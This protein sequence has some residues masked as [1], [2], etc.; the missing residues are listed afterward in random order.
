MPL[1]LWASLATAPR[2]VAAPAE[3]E[4]TTVMTT[5]VVIK[6][7]EW[8][9]S[10]VREVWAEGEIAAEV[11]DIQRTL[12]TPE[13]FRDFMPYVKGAYHVG[14]PE[15]DGS[16]YVYTQVAPPMISARD[17]VVRVWMDES[18]KADGSGEFRQ[19]WEAVPDKLPTRSSVVRVRVNSGS[20]HIRPSV[21]SGFSWV[22]YRFAFDPGGALP[23][24]VANLGNER[25]VLAT[26]RAVE[27][28]ARRLAEERRRRPRVAVE[29]AGDTN[30]VAPGITDAGTV[31]DGSWV[32]LDAGSAPDSPVGPSQQRPRPLPNP[33]PSVEAT[34]PGVPVAQPTGAQ[35]AAPKRRGQ[36]RVPKTPRS[37]AVPQPRAR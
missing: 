6:N 11:Q 20:W 25:G 17:Y 7:R 12:C 9:G 29:D 32:H 30:P 28:Q 13:K 14:T 22:V 4:W 10:D 35:S 23:G 5:P 21:R 36:V 18:V 27:Q 3:S 2:V 24:F 8:K 34:H 19:R 37:T 31:D 15:P 33:S 1:L 16:D 26:L